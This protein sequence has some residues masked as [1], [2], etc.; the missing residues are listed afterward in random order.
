MMISV[1]SWHDVVPSN[2]IYGHCRYYSR[3]HLFGDLRWANAQSGG[4]QIVA[5]YVT[6]TVANYSSGKLPP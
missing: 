5:A 4:R 6:V 2:Q 3:R 1:L